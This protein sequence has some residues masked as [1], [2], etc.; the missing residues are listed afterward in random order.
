MLTGGAVD[1]QPSF[2]P[3]G[4]SI[5]FVR[6]DSRTR[7]SAIWLMRSDGSDQHRILSE[8]QG[9][10][11]PSFSPDGRRLLLWDGKA[12]VTVGLDGG[13]PRRL[14]V[15]ESDTTGAVT[16]PY[17]SWAPDGSKVVFDQFRADGRNRSDIWRVGADGRGLRRLTASPGFDS[18]P[19]W[20]PLVTRR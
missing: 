10:S 6:I 8:L 13:A 3:D 4:R 12:L 7:R 15:L 18:D 2:S 14:V 11:D 1:L 16:E 20:Q 19:S 9:V 5:V 17:P